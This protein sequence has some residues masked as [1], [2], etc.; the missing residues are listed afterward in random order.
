MSIPVVWTWEGEEGGRK[1]G[2]ED[3]GRRRRGKK[4]WEEDGGTK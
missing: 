3:R 4:I 2:E 1:K